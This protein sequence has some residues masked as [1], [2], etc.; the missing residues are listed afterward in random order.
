[1]PVMPYTWAKVN[2]QKPEIHTVIEY[3]N[4]ACI[5]MI[6]MIAYEED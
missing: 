2:T 1:M 6:E 5:S 4:W 3:S